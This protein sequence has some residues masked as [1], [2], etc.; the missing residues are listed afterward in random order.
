MRNLLPLKIAILAALAIVLVLSF[1]VVEP[2]ANWRQGEIVVILPPADS[3]DRPFNQHLAELFAAHLGVKLKP[4]ELFPYQVRQALN[5]D[6]AHFSAVGMRANEADDELLFG[7]PYQ[8]VSELVVCSGR[9]AAKLAELETRIV[10]VVAGSAQEAALRAT[11]QKHPSLYWETVDKARP[12][13][14]LESVARGEI[15]CTV[16]NEEQIAYMRNFHPRMEATFEI[17]EPSQLAWSFAPNR[18]AT[19]YAEMEIFFARIEEDG[20]LDRLL[21]RFYG[22]NDRIIPFDAAAFLTKINTLLPR[23]R[24]MFEEAASLTG[25]EWQLLAAVAYRESH[26]NPLATSYTK[27]RGMMMLTEDTADRMKVS[28]RLDAR[29]S[30]MAGSRYLQLLKEQLPLRIDEPDRTWFALAAYNQGMGHLEDARILAQRHGL[31]ADSW[32]DVQ[33]VMPKL[34]NPGVAKTLKHG[35]ARG[36]E[37]VVFVET[38][39]LHHDMLQRISRNE[40]KQLLPPDYQIKLNAW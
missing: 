15:D 14:L 13:D 36:E 21:E 28:N 18:D 31:N 27:V 17:A 32:V 16:A 38:V 25:I 23:Y 35:Y 5:K 11:L 20:T 34:R 1:G 33:K 24:H 29:E 3:V 39:R 2:L 30:I 19:L 4:L 37:A 8:A 10:T 7:V 9:P 12:G 26:W 40:Y 6:L 22:H